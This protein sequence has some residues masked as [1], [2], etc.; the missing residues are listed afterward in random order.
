MDESSGGMTPMKRAEGALERA[1]AKSWW[2]RAPQRKRNIGAGILIVE[3]SVL[4]SVGGLLLDD[5]AAWIIAGFMWVSSL[6]FFTGLAI[7]P[8]R[9]ARVAVRA[10]FV[11]LV[12][13]V[14]GWIALVVA[15]FLAR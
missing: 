3:I 4:F 10:L 7:S 2:M 12:L 11:F 9:T 6:A 1:A 5:A 13:G 14:L 15:L 8:V